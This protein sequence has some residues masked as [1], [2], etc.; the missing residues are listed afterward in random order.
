MLR[1]S[2][3]DTSNQVILKL[4]GSLVGTWVMELEEAWRVAR[5]RFA[6][7]LLC[8]DLTA[9]DQ[10]DRAGKYL[11][12]LLRDRGV[13]LVASGLVMTETVAEMA[14]EWHLTERP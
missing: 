7:R 6:S 1:I 4:E 3:R 8:V 11:L 10:V 14:K 5:S 12:V 9:V 2:V 13:R